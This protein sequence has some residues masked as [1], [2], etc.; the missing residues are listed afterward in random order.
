MRWLP[1][2]AVP[3][4]CLAFLYAFQRYYVRSPGKITQPI[5][6]SNCNTILHATLLQAL[7]NGR[8]I[9]SFKTAN[10]TIYLRGHLQSRDGG[11]TVQPQTSIDFEPIT[12]SPEGA[13]FSDSDIF[14]ALD[15]P[16]IRIRAGIY[17]VQGWRSNDDLQ[18][19]ETEYALI[20]VPNGPTRPRQKGEWL[21]FVCLPHYF[22][23]T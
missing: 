9:R 19:I 12:A 3:L 20:E 10:G 8:W 22:G 15:G 7:N 21:W 2:I 1:K 4:I 18:T 14:Y 16:A 17:Q 6:L 23:I 11:Q 5:D 13:I